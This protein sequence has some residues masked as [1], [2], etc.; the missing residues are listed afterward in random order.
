MLREIQ[1]AAALAVTQ[2]HMQPEVA[3]EVAR[4]F[5]RRLASYTYLTPSPPVLAAASSIPAGSQEG[6]AM[7][8]EG[9]Q[10]DQG[11]PLGGT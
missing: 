6:G 8:N 3:G 9:L 11:P 4:S 5:A 1:E 7:L 10:R 2:Q